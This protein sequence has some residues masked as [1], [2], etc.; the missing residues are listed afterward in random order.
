MY[1]PA[2][3]HA[4]VT[5][6]PRVALSALQVGLVRLQGAVSEDKG[7]RS[8]MEDVAV[9]EFDAR[10]PGGVVDA[11][12]RCVSALPPPEGVFQPC[13]PSCQRPSA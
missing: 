12:T 9:M 6:R 5:A 1:I 4:T 8:C 7:S 10:Q 11:G 3:T 2:C 13:L